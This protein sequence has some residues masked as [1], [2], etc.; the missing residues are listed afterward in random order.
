MWR[1]DQGPKSWS[2]E[3]ER[4][5]RSQGEGVRGLPAER[6]GLSPPPAGSDRQVPATGLHPRPC[7]PPSFKK[8]GYGDAPLPLGSADT[9]S[10]RE[11]VCPR[12]PGLQLPASHTRFLN[13][14]FCCYF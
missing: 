7:S 10:Q 13:P 8:L 14:G 9:P 2:R 1:G 4:P 6:H 3:A 11:K 5:V 12:D